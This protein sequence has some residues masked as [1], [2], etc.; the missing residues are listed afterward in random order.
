MPP[1]TVTSQQLDQIQSAIFYDD[2][3]DL[4]K[5][6]Q[7]DSAKEVTIDDNT[8]ALHKVDVGTIMIEGLSRIGGLDISFKLDEHQEADVQDAI[9][10]LAI[11]HY[12]SMKL[13]R[14]ISHQIIISTPYQPGF[15][16]FREAIPLSSLLEGITSDERPQLLFVDGNGSLHERRVGSAVIIGQLTNIP[17]IGIGKDFHPVFDANQLGV[18][19]YEKSQKGM[20]RHATQVLK[21]RGDWFSIL[22]FDRASSPV[23]AVS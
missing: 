11:L 15:L 19:E 20:K 9:A 10:T 16:S 12:P 8:T 4:F 17:T 5:V 1:P 3:D 2:Y 13:I 7:L 14:S 22:G 6:H 23:G 21:Q 18:Q